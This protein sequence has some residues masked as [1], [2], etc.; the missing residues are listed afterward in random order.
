MKRSNFSED[1]VAYALRQAASDQFPV[2]G[3]SPTTDW[4][5][6]EIVRDT[7]D[8]E[9]PAGYGSDALIVCFGFYGGETRLALRSG[10]SDGDKRV[11]ES[12]IRAKGD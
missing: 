1:Q 5:A 12:S 8:I 2:D 4:Q 7:F 3:Q 6:G 10:P 9:V 11:R